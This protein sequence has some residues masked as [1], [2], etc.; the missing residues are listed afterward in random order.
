MAESTWTLTDGADRTYVEQLEVTPQLVGGS[1][2]GYRIHKRRLQ[3]GMSD[4][5][6]VVHVDNGKLSFEVVPTRGMGLWKAWF[7]GQQIGWNSRHPEQTHS[8]PDRNQ[9]GGLTDQT[10]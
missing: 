3:G 10:V 4:G 7:G 6:D 8:E 9:T 1:A 5:V 2:Q